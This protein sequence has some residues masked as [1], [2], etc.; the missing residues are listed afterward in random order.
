[1]TQKVRTERNSLSN[2]YED[3]LRLARGCI[4][5]RKGELSEPDSLAVLERLVVQ[6]V[7]GAMLLL[8]HLYWEGIIVERDD[9]RAFQLISKAVAMDFVPAMS[10]LG[11]LYFSGVG[12]NKDF[13]K[14]LH[15]Y[16][17]GG[18]RRN[19]FDYIHVGG[20]A[21]D[22]FEFQSSFGLSLNYVQ[23][24]A[25]G[26]LLEKLNRWL[27]D[28]KRNV[29][30]KQATVLESNPNAF[31]G[32]HK[33]CLP[34]KGSIGGSPE[35]ILTGEEAIEQIGWRDASLEEDVW[36]PMTELGFDR[37]GLPKFSVL[38]SLVIERNGFSWSLDDNLCQRI[39]TATSVPMPS[40]V[41]GDE[42]LDITL[43]PRVIEL[44]VTFTSVGIMG[45]LSYRGGPSLLSFDNI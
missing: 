1:M 26:R 21:L 11:G 8:G 27:L 28:C 25:P 36:F 7:P 18:N 44:S 17:Q 5:G 6:D 14:A 20:V 24:L 10:S 45:A 37:G 12:C 9:S 43:C 3:Q 34:F 39:R 4:Y 33:R 30:A 23:H 16:E 41:E 40:L 38:Q 35:L 22:V 19:N 29:I 42:Y 31:A 2:E 32:T 15:W 13:E